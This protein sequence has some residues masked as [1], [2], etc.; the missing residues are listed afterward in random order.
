M[1]AR[2]YY[3]TG[4]EVDMRIGHDESLLLYADDVACILVNSMN[5]N[6]LHSSATVRRD[7]H[8]WK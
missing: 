1:R 4:L 5:K 8:Y 7:F 2:G 6:C 3:M